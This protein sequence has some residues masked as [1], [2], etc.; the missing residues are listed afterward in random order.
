MTETIEKWDSLVLS[1]ADFCMIGRCHGITC[2][3][4]LF[5]CLEATVKKNTWMRVISVSVMIIFSECCSASYLISAMF[6]VLTQQLRGTLTM[7]FER[8]FTVQDFTD[9]YQHTY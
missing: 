1:R 2:F 5:F 7:A 8:Y 9:M 4:F 6:K 3:H